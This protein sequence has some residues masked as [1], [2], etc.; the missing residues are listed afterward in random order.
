MAT[1]AIWDIKDN[2][3]RVLDYT[4]NPNK[5]EVQE[6]DYQY[7]GLNQVIS[8]TTQDLKT[9]KQLY[10]TGINCSYPTAF[11]EMEITKKGF[12]KTDGILAFHG[13]QSFVPGEVN[14][15]TAHQI[16]IELANLMWGDRFEVLV[17]THLD[18]AHFHNHFVVN[19]VSFVDGK[20]YYDNRE[21]YKRMRDLS[22]SLCRKYRLSVIENPQLKGS[23]YSQWNAEKKHELTW[24]DFIKEDVD[25]AIAHSMSM[26]QFYRH[27]QE[28]GYHIK[29]GKHVAIKPKNKERYVR[30]RS[31]DKLGN[32]TT[33]KIEERI[34]EQKFVKFQSLNMPKQKTKR[35]YYHGNIK[36]NKCKITGF[37]A[38]YFRYLYLLGVLP[39]NAP[40]KKRVHFLLRD[41][42]RQ[43]DHIT[44]EVTLISKKN[45]TNLSELEANQYFASDK[46]ENLIKERRCIYNKIRR[47]KSPDKK[48]MLQQDV[49]T[50]SLQIKD[51]RK[52]V[53]LYE[54]IKVRSI[55]IKQKLQ[56]IHEEEKE[57]DKQ[58][59]ENKKSKGVK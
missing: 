28:L 30:L 8:Y 55:S 7:N 2:L 36:D 12:N 54:G 23:H 32:Y 39:K 16:G 19:S 29:Y 46:L 44:K 40:H 3:K 50:L 31:L 25:F 11:Q 13:Y 38:L 4:S 43:L 52:E 47:C 17:S 18:K 49:E 59:R 10:V 20:K 45:I 53:V 33:D 34:Y 56:Q 35:F 22:D 5:T 24:R 42:L 48:E 41:D 21:N 26:K 51:L 15:E 37:K 1:T 27:L 9:E 57:L 58:D 6:H 14:A